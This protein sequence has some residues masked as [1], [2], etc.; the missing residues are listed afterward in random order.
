MPFACPTVT[1]PNAFYWPHDYKICTSLEF[2][3]IRLTQSLLNCRHK[4]S[5]RI[6]VLM[7]Q[8]KTMKVIANHFLDP[9]IT[10][11]PNVGTDKSWVW[12]AFDF[13][14]NELVEQVRLDLNLRGFVSASTANWYSCS[15]GH[16]LLSL[17]SI[18][19]P[20][21]YSQSS[22]ECAITKMTDVQWW[23][24]LLLKSISDFYCLLFVRHLQFA[25]VR[26]SSQKNSRRHS[27]PARKTWR[28]YWLGRTRKKLQKERMRSL[29]L[30]NLL[31][32]R[33]MLRKRRVMLSPLMHRL[34]DC[35]G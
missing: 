31:K 13:S 29:L 28:H 23:V 14:D 34:I 30:S 9:R 33:V 3:R 7:R 12:G 26:R 1:S 22:V 21:S 17:A 16:C 27:L 18:K 19:S 6:R 4:E 35:F 10:L 2:V 8:E 15:W 5:S 11:S 20:H 24:S 32:L 25:S